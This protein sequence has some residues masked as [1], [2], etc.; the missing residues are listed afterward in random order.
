[1]NEDLTLVVL[2]AGLGSRFGGLKQV[3]KVG[4]NGEF[5]LDYSVYDAKVAGFTKVVFI[6][7]EENYEIFKNTIGKRC[8]KH[9]KVEYAYQNNN[10]LEK[11]NIP[12][13]RVKPFGTAH[14]ILCAKDN[15]K[16][17]F[18][19]ISADD[20]FGRDAFIKGAEYLKNNNDFC[21]IGYKIGETLS[22]E[23]NVKRG[24]CME[25]DGY[26]TKIVESEVEKLSDKVKC[27]PLSGSEEFYV[28][29]SQPVSMLMF[30]LN[31]KVLTEIED[32][33]DEFFE[34]NKDNMLKCE[35]LIPDVL[36]KMIKE[37]KVK[38]KVIPTTSKWFGAT[39]KEDVEKIKKSILE[40]I[41]KGVYKYN[42]WD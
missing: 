8:E 33:L 39:Y 6:I 34:N 28:D 3:E 38:I 16:G 37:N 41:D 30:G 22:N 26:L 7:K 11:Y 9:I 35:Y 12:E 13:E 15:I 32:G 25:K 2:A 21:V 4:P 20:F 19:I 36:D 23:G 29:F 1:M 17:K 18:L 27:M 5:M 14:A 31:E 24:I 42:L 10:L 40:L